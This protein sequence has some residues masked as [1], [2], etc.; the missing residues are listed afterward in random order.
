MSS[1][2]GQQKRRRTGRGEIVPRAYELEAARR[3]FFAVLWELV[4][5]ALDEIF[6]SRSLIHSDRAAFRAWADRWQKTYRLP[7][8]WGRA[9]ALL[10]PAVE[11]YAVNLMPADLNEGRWFYDPGKSLLEPFTVRGGKVANHEGGYSIALYELHRYF[12]YDDGT[13]S[14][15]E[16]DTIGMYDPRRET[17][18]DAVARIM[19]GLEERLRDVLRETREHDAIMGD[20]VP[21]R[22]LPPKQ[23]FEWTVRYQV[24]GES[25]AKIA[26]A[27]GIREARTVSEAVRSVAG[28]IG[29]TLREP[30]KGGRPRKA[31]PAQAARC[32][33]I[34][35]TKKTPASENRLSR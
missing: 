2:S 10:P 23:H 20:T 7:D 11:D 35:Q 14:T 15:D 3:E 26:N 34:P 19:P 32:I 30:D 12:E 33:A 17:E 6:D 1:V 24:L 21:T 13:E 27:D 25:F 31:K 18:D 29:L 28:L 5:E 16:D 8:P 22:M 4:P 9:A